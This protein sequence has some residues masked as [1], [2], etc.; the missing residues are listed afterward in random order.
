MWTE[1]CRCREPRPV[2]LK[3]FHSLRSSVKL[4]GCCLAKEPQFKMLYVPVNTIVNVMRLPRLDSTEGM[5]E[6]KSKDTVQSER[7]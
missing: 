7:R 6:Q 3:V 5:K 2:M 4:V 1:D